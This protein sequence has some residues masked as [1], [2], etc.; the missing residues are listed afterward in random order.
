MNTNT[1]LFFRR[2]PSILQSRHLFLLFVF[3]SVC[4]LLNSVTYHIK[5]D[6][7]GNF[8][9][10]QEGINASADT[11]TVLVYPGTYYENIDYIGKNITVASLELTTG[12]E[13]YIYSTIIDGQRL[14]SCVS[15]ISQETDTCLRGLTIT[16]GQGVDDDPLFGGGIS[17]FADYQE[18]VQCD[19][20][21]CHIINNFSFVTGGLSIINGLVFLSGNSIKQNFAYKTGGGLAIGGESQVEFDP[22]NRCSIY[23]NVAATGVEMFV[24]SIHS[25]EQT[26]IVDTF[27]VAEPTRYFAQKYPGDDNFTYNFDILH[28]IIEPI[29]HDLYVSPEGNDE[30]SGLTADEPLKTINLAVRNIAS[31]SDNPHTVHLAEG[32]YSK[33]LNQQQLT[34][35]CKSNVNIIGEN[36]NTTIIDGEMGGYPFFYAGTDYDNSTIKN[37]TF[38]NGLTNN[39]FI[40]ISYSDFIKFEN[41]LIQD[42]IVLDLGGA[43]CSATSGGNIQLK[44]VTIDNID[45]Q[46]SASGQFNGTTFFK[47]ED[48]IFSNNT[49]SSSSIAPAAGLHTDGYGDFIIEN[50]E[51]INNNAVNT[52]WE[53]Y[54]SALIISY[55]NQEVGD[56]IIN[57]CLFADNSVT[58]GRSTIYVKLLNDHNLTFTNNTVINNESPYGIEVQGNINCRNNIL[59]NIGDYEIALFDKSGQGIISEIDI[60]NCNILGGESAI[61][62]QNGVNI[63]NWLEGNIDEDPLFLL[64]G[65]YPYQ[66]T[67]DSPCVDTGTPDTLGLFLPPWDLLH[68]YRVW[69]GDNNGTAIIDMGCYEFGADEYPVGITNDQL[70]VT[71]YQL[72]NFPNPFNPETKIVF[73]LPES[74]QVKLEIYNIKGQK[75]KTL[76]DCYMSPGRS[77]MIWNGRD[78]NGKR[79]S[80]G[81]YFYRLQT[82]K[83]YITKKM[84]LLK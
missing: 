39:D 16:N 47:A 45:M 25:D 36:T 34:F 69:D 35:G 56:V 49:S 84:L 11:D 72:T 30:N 82:P 33:S 54:A 74:G 21:N 9:T 59:R 70:P 29:D 10:I 7:T 28:H 79:V 4:S 24:Q 73:D 81:V 60:S 44:N 19:I 48:C 22:V 8:I 32:I 13:Q 62:N 50:C 42:C 61:Y 31:N 68:N 23:N 63:V 1:K 67:L 3:V 14:S 57:N 20:I 38:Q 17:I 53:G 52:L 76:L 5:Q 55:Y 12:D 2:C 78:D 18:F 58:F 40:M 71:D 26:V 41:L 64:T 77:E 43:I 6:G 75:V 80:S 15:I 66:L 51:F 65:D 83:K 37:M 27:T 46:L